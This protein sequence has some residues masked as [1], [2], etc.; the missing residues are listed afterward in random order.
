M[1]NQREQD[2]D[3]PMTDTCLKPT[4]AKKPRHREPS[5]SWTDF[6]LT[7][8][9]WIT[10]STQHIELTK[11]QDSSSSTTLL[12]NGICLKTQFISWNTD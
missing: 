9:K 6:F 3:S 2:I 1:K 11:E 4:N 5:A 10:G 8:L 7:P 12:L